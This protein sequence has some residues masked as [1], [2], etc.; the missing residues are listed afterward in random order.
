[1][2]ILGVVNELK[3][4]GIY[5]LGITY[6]NVDE[7]SAKDILNCIANSDNKFFLTIN[8]K[9]NYILMRRSHYSDV[10]I[11]YYPLNVNGFMGIRRLNNIK[12]TESVY[13]IALNTRWY[14]SILQQAFRDKAKM[15]Y[16]LFL[17]LLKYG[18]SYKDYINGTIIRE[19]GISY[20]D[21]IDLLILS[22]NS[23]IAKSKKRDAKDEKLYWSGSFVVGFNI[24][25][26]RVNLVFDKSFYACEC[27]N[28]FLNEEKKEK[29]AELIK[30]GF[31]ADL[32]LDTMNSLYDRVDIS[33][34]TVVNLKVSDFA[35]KNRCEL[36]VNYLNTGSIIMIDEFS[37][38][39][40]K[41]LDCRKDLTTKDF[42]ELFSGSKKD[43]STLIHLVSEG[44]EIPSFVS[45][46]KSGRV[47]V[48]KDNIGDI[49]T[50]C[51]N[52]SLYKGCNIA[53]K[54]KDGYY[55]FMLVD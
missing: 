23:L 18:C 26:N 10:G 35:T 51:L 43:T 17:Y 45:M 21:A 14:K 54:E 49:L 8:D 33:S 12:P 47:E 24:V 39:F 25:G 5:D 1:M 50:A 7:N 40:Y 15:Y 32:S 9:G 6:D 37:I 28:Y 31:L 4:K 29:N 46:L 48:T 30:K 2:N 52:I 19:V 34:G 42:K 55:S 53:I 44:G 16:E 20:A 22:Y 38:F 13:E 36:L 41:T 11:F 27:E 3:N